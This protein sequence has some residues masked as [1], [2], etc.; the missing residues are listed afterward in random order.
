MRA[1]VRGV[2]VPMVTLYDDRGQVD[3]RGMRHLVDFLIARGIGGLFPCGTTGEGPL[4]ST[5]ERMAIAETVIDAAR[6]RVPVIVHTGAITTEDA[7]LLTRHAHDVGA[8]GAA[9]FAPYYYTY[10]EDALYRHFMAVAEEVPDFPLYLYNIPSLTGNL[11]PVTLVRRLMADCPHLVGVKDS[12]GSLDYFMRLMELEEERP[13]V[14]ANG[15]DAHI[16][17]AVALGCRACVSGNANVVPD[18]VV[19][20]FVTAEQGDLPAARRLQRQLNQV[21]HLLEDGTNL[22]LFKGILRMRDL[23]VTAHVRPPLPHVPPDLV[24][25]RWQALQDIGVLS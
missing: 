2:I 5:R 25:E 10:S 22:S 8:D 19:H 4:L 21:R 12:S 3:H 11:I 17:A 20:L 6:G 18:L 24:R 15:S 16:L 23:G 7:R 9:I 1:H 14:V 13:F